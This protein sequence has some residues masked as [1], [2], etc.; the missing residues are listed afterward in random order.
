MERLLLYLDDID[1]VVFALALVGERRGP[2]IGRALVNLL[3]GLSIVTAIAL[4]ARLPALSAGVFAL[5]LVILLYRSVTRPI[6][7]RAR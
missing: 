5:V 6:A 7:A 2:R 4:T 1:D 3:L